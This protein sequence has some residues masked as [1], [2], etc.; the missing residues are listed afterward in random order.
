M[1]EMNYHV[2]S[3]ATL[4]KSGIFATVLAVGV[5]VAIILPAEFNKDPTGIG[6]LLG[7][8]VLSEPAPVVNDI[9]IEQQTSAEFKSNEVEVVVPAGRGVEY[10]FQLSKY[11]NLTYE[12][13]TNGEAL[14]F[15]FHGEPA[16]DTT[17]YFESY[18]ITTAN[19]MKGSMT[20]PF[21]GSHGWYWKNSSDKPVKI[22]LKTQGNYQILGLKQ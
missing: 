14:F 18:A 8:N 11:E 12:W 4:I 7:L 3:K 5:Y 20:V 13:I 22:L 19:E 21:D 10:K 2:H 9:K 16:G 6:V 1:S 15:D 17:G